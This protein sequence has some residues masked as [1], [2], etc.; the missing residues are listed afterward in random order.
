MKSTGKYHRK[1]FQEHGQE[2]G[3]G[4]HQR[5]ELRKWLCYLVEL[6][7]HK[8]SRIWNSHR[9][10]KVMTDVIPRSSRKSARTWRQNRWENESFE[11]VK[12]E[13]WTKFS[14]FSN[15]FRFQVEVA[16]AKFDQ[17]GNNMLDYRFN[18]KS[19]S[20][21]HLLRW[22]IIHS[23]SNPE[24]SVTWSTRD[25]KRTEAVG[26]SSLL[27]R[28]LKLVAKYFDS[29][30]ASIRYGWSFCLLLCPSKIEICAFIYKTQEK[31]LQHLYWYLYS[32]KVDWENI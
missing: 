22:F 13:I 7:R 11:Y 26:C 31:N 12:T 15:S 25:K 4:G 16:F 18:H 8:M 10:M 30:L 27:P 32:S 28:P 3:W 20:V 17:T 24:S 1:A 14:F 5:G 2:W 9:E 21:E 29:F 23:N 6:L 19:S